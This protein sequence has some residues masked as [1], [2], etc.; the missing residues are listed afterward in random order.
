MSDEKYDVIVIGGGS[1]GLACANK[2]TKNK[3]NV[4]LLE[5]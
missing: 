5:A 3:L 1:S 4:L 2:L